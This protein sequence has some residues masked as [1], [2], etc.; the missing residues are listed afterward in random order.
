MRIPAALVVLALVFAGVCRSARCVTA[1]DSLGLSEY[2]DY[3]TRSERAMPAR[4]EGGDL[5]W[6]P[7]S[8]RPEAMTDL[9][10]GRQVRR[11]ISDAAVNQRAADRNATVIDW[12]GAIR[13]SGVRIPDLLAVLQDYARYP[14]IYNPMIYETRFQPIAGSG[15]GSYDVTFGLQNTYRGVSLFP[16][17]YAFQVKA[18]TDYSG[19]S[20]PAGGVLLVHQRSSEIRESDSGVPGRADFLQ[21]Y[22]DHGIL[23]ALNTYWRAR[24]HGS[25]LYVEFE[26]ITL[27]RSIQ[28]FSCKIGLF[29]VPKL[30]V[31]GVM[32]SLPS[33][34][35]DLML[36]ATK[37]ECEREAARK[38]PRA[39]RN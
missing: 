31:S 7:S 21:P 15:L 1:V 33:E 13:I 32:D 24:Q 18:R 5:A 37:A 6:I 9:N 10:A 12:I 30:L 14:S 27:A 16:Q 3:V 11:N 22:H 23:W 28:D 39:S 4:F 29:P 20:Q 17:H 8:S 2:E 19:D 25:D 34:S 35:L 26:A 36:T 38:P